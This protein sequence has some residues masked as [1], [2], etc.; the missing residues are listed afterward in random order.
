VE[1]AAF[2][3]FDENDNS[4]LSLVTHMWV[5]LSDFL[6]TFYHKKDTE[7]WLLRKKKMPKVTK[8]LENMPKD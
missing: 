2:Y 7:G 8:K 5:T 6:N 3:E 4:S 1:I